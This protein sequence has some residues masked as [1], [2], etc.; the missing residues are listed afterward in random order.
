[1]YITIWGIFF[2]LFDWNRATG[3][4]SFLLF[5]FFLTRP[6]DQAHTRPNSMVLSPSGWS[7]CTV[8]Y[9]VHPDP[10]VVTKGTPRPATESSVAVD[11]P[12]WAWVAV[13]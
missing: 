2:N 8:T 10:S 13:F 7:L 9:I 1:M 5:P 11:A 4:I 6:S 12:L 3:Y